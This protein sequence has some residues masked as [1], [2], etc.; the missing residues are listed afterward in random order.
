LDSRRRAGSFRRWKWVGLYVLFLAASV[1]AVPFLVSWLGRNGMGGLVRYGP[2]VMIAGGLVW[3][4]WRFQGSPHRGSRRWI[5]L[6]LALGAGYGIFLFRLTRYPVERVHLLEYGLLAFLCGW[7]ME[8]DHL[9]RVR[10]ALYAVTGVLLVGFLDE[11]LQGLVPGRYY[12][13][14]D[15]ALN[16]SSG[17]FGILFYLLH[18][19]LNP[20][21]A[22]G[23]GR[24]PGARTGKGTGDRIAALV[25]LAVLGCAGYLQNPGFDRSYFFGSWQRPSRCGCGTET[26]SFSAPDRF[27]WEDSAGN[28]A[29]GVFAVEGN[30]LEPA[31]LNFTLHRVENSSECGMRRSGTKDTLSSEVF[32]GDGL[33]YYGSQENRPWRRAGEL[34]RERRP[35]AL[36]PGE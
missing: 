25:V 12:D 5:L 11:V 1:Y 26:L 17:I 33:F 28:S 13:P 14:R 19:R 3:L 30:R 7:A 23:R 31:K 16:A 34:W 18:R 20:E 21:P 6:F 9:G 22:A 8:E 15:L 32:R 2:G 4:G 36:G 35:N 24:S 27:S 29:E 10:T